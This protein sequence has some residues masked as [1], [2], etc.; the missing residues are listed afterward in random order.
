MGGLRTCCSQRTRKSG[1]SGC[2]ACS[3]APASASTQLVLCAQRTNGAIDALLLFD[4]ALLLL[5]VLLL[6]L[7]ALYSLVKLLINTLQCKL[8]KLC[9]TMSCCASASR[10]IWAS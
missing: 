2:S 8:F 10:C 6:L 1:C 5:N 9:S 7:L 3:C 4:V